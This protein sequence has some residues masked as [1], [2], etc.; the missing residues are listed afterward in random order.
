M[1]K[2]GGI[3]TSY[4]A[5]VHECSRKT[6]LIVFLTLASLS[7]PKQARAHTM[8]QETIFAK[9]ACP[10]SGKF[11][12]HPRSYPTSRRPSPFRPAARQTAT[13]RGP[14][15]ET[16]T[17]APSTWGISGVPYTRCRTCDGN[18]SGIPNSD[19]CLSVDSSRTAH[20][21]GSDSWV[22]SRSCDSRSCNGILF[23]HPSHQSAPRSPLWSFR[24]L[25]MM[26]DF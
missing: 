3:A 19:P 16:S 9:T 25:G 21:P 2:N 12:S 10:K 14:C 20:L 24:M 6:S 1:L 5:R 26:C 13:L 7:T 11:L 4:D 23:V 8:V 18:P 15:I 17:I 22:S